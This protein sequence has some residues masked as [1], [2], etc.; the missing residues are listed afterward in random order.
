LQ[1]YFYKFAL[2]GVDGVS[3]VASVGGYVRNYEITLNQDRLIQYDLDIEEI[4]DA[5]TKNNNDSGARVIL[6]NG[7]EQIISAR[8]YLKSKKDIENITI[9][10]QNNIPLKIKD[11]AEVNL[12]SNDRRGVAELN[13][14]GEVVGGIVVT[15]YGVDVHSVI[16]NVKAKLHSLNIDDVEIVEVYDRTSL[17]DAAIDTLKRTLIEES[18]IVMLIVAIFCFI[19]EVL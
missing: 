18:I 3:E 17:I 1:D 5:I 16:K 14:E 9:K 6:E 19:L 13:G 7:Y 11:I 8:A 12:T 4:K 2:L 15:R 10:T